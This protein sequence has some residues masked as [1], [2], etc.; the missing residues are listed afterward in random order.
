M[1][2]QMVNASLKANNLSPS[3][4]DNCPSENDAPFCPIGTLACNSNQRYC[5]YPDRNIMVSTYMMPEY[6]YC[7]AKKIG[8]KDGNLPFQISGINVW[9]RQQGRDSTNCSNIK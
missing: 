2:N 4:N 6:D 9:Q 1:N 5:Y 3:N 8:K 7:P